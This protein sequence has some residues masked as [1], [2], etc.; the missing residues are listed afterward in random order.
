MNERI[1]IH[2]EQRPRIFVRLHDPAAPA[3]LLPHLLRPLQSHLS[4]LLRQSHRQRRPPPEN[5]VRFVVPLSLMRNLT[6]SF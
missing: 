1:R 2:V 4:A 6:E 3:L 5:E